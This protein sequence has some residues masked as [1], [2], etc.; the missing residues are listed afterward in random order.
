MRWSLLCFLLLL[1]FAGCRKDSTQTGSQGFTPLNEKD[2]KLIFCLHPF[3]SQLSLLEAWQPIADYLTKETGYEV[4]LT[5]AKDYSNLIERFINKEVDMAL[6]GSFAY[7]NVQE[8]T[9]IVPLV[10]RV[11][12]GNSSYRSLLI[13]RKGTP[14]KSITDIK[15]SNLAFTDEKSTSGY[16]FPLYM[17]SEAG[18]TPLEKSFNSIIWAGNHDNAKLLVYSGQVDAA[19][20]TS[21][22]WKPYDKDPRLDELRVLTSS[23]NFPLGPISVRKDLPPEVQSKLRDAFLKINMNDPET[24]KLAL[25]VGIDGFSRCSDKT[26]NYIR[27]IKEKLEEL[28]I[29][30]LD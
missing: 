4:E 29:D 22:R 14:Y 3:Q 17:L 8:Q 6:L 18:L 12:S 28:G 11:V 30:T 5:F 2:D 21:I 23:K 7:I 9:E 20:I 19:F 26:Y 27:E 16:L 15:G 25:N 10:Q 1:L 13:V 24:E